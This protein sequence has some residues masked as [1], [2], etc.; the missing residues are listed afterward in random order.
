MRVALYEHVTG[1]GKFC[2]EVS[3][4]PG[5]LQPVLASVD[6]SAFVPEGLAIV[7]AVAADLIDGGVAVDLLWDVALPVPT[8]AVDRLHLVHSHAERQSLLQQAATG[9]D[10]ALVVAPELDSALVDV[11]R[12]VD[13]VGGRRLGPSLSFVEITTDKHRTAMALAAAGLPVPEGRILENGERLPRDFSYP[14]VWKPCDGAGSH[15]VRLVP[16]AGAA[17][18]GKGPPRPASRRRLERFC[19]GLPASVAVLC[20]PR[21]FLPLTPCRQ[22]LA[23]DGTFAYYGGAWPLPGELVERAQHLAVE[24]AAAIPGAFGYVGVD[25]VLGAD[26]HGR[27]D[28]VIE[29]NPRL[30]TSYIG[31][32]EVYQTN[33]AMAMLDVAVGRDVSLALRGVDQ[34]EFT[35]AG[36]VRC[37]A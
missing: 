16:R 28:V 32:R 3:D 37:G 12:Q 36:R 7:Q 22:L 14:A 13:T 23:S 33:L 15:E 31:L 6:W 21:S 26:V 29:I 17:P 11:C 35:A 10:W 34:L 24:A 2:A 25:L 1:G 20:G 8:L 9:A 18:E 5:S 19:P 27:E 4:S 30:T